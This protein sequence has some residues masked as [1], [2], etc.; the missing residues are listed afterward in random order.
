M[1]KKEDFIILSKMSES[2][3]SCHY[4]IKTC[5]LKQEVFFELRMMQKTQIIQYDE[6]KLV[7]FEKKV[8]Q[9]IRHPFLVNYVYT[10]QDYDCLFLVTEMAKGGYLYHYLRSSVFFKKDIVQFYVA[11]MVLAIQHLHRKNLFYNLLIPDNIMLDEIGHIKLRYDFCNLSGL[12]EENYKKNIEYISIDYLKDKV[13]N[14][15]SDYWSLGI[16]MYE[17]LFGMTPFRASSYDEIVSNMMNKR[18]K[19][20]KNIDEPTAELLYILLDKHSFRRIGKHENEAVLIKECAFFKGMD[21]DLLEKRMIKPPL[22]MKNMSD[23]Y[24]NGV[25]MTRKFHN[26]FD[27]KDNDGYGDTFEEY[28]E[29]EIGITAYCMNLDTK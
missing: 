13:V 3:F 16:I 15:S 29:I 25:S 6:T 14:K 5:N 9:D 1:F 18:I 22:Q 8:R 21:W 26:Y 10:F 28:T 23:S 2:L 7:F 20:L 17:M 27:K 24:T 4:L 12:N 19:F 11:E